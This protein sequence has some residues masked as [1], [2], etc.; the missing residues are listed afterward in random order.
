MSD[1]DELIE[2]VE[3]ANKPTRDLFR[4][5]F[6][7][8]F[9]YGVTVVP[10]GPRWVRYSAFIKMVDAEAWESA[11]LMLVPEGY[12]W[13]IGSTWK[14]KHGN[15]P[16]VASVCIAGDYARPIIGATSALAIVI[17]SLKA[18]KQSRMVGKEQK[19]T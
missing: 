19:S 11:A 6:E 13:V 2:R 7:A 16:A 8:V 3:K 1:L 5:C 17:A 4:E 15:V 12:R 14:D 9:G 18:L 10:D